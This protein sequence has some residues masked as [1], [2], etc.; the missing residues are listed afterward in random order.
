MDNKITELRT[1]KDGK[2]K[3]PRTPTYGHKP[4]AN[5]R[6]SYRLGISLIERLEATTRLLSQWHK[7]GATMWP[8][9]HYRITTSDIA[10]NLIKIG[11]QKVEEA[12][13]AQN[14]SGLE[15]LLDVILQEDYDEKEFYR[16]LDYEHTKK[17]GAAGTKKYKD[18][19]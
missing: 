8:K 12:G 15:I 3:A 16:K 1:D 6:A 18:T 10:R 2:R 19:P 17:Y 9:F 14:K 13:Q 5:I 11:F 4:L 7:E